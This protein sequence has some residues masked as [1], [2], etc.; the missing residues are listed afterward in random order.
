MKKF[1]LL[2]ISAIF[3]FQVSKSQSKDLVNIFNL[4]AEAIDKGQYKTADSLFSLCIEES[5]NS[6]IYYN[7][8]Q[9]RRLLSDTCGFCKDLEIASDYF[10]DKE[11]ENQYLNYCLRYIDTTF[12]SKD[13]VKINK[14]EKYRFYQVVRRPVCDTLTYLNFH[15]IKAKRAVTPVNAKNLSAI[16]N[17]GTFYSDI[18]GQAYLRDTVKIFSY[19]RDLSI[20]KI[21]EKSTAFEDFSGYL[22]KKYKNLKTKRDE[23]IHVHLE[24]SMNS[25]GKITNV[26]FLDDL[27]SKDIVTNNNL[28]LEISDFFQNTLVLDPVRFQ[29]QRV[30][31][32]TNYLFDF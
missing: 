11:A 29:N 12:Y 30:F 9:V 5:T 31:Y 32:E 24:L 27:N 7:R 18:I 13:N 2:S 16:V 17:A 23:L 4:A 6:D 14:N 10:G 8:S 15:D 22:D 1:I 20:D 28:K 25:D 3:L 26:K 21:L 19:I